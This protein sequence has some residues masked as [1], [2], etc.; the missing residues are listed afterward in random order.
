ML[1]HIQR[2]AQYS[3]FMNNKLLDAASQLHTDALSANKGAYFGSILGTLNHVLVGDLLWL[4]RF[5]H[6]STAYT[7]LNTL[8][9][10]PV[11][12]ALDQQLYN[13]LIDFKVVRQQLDT[14]ILSWVNQITA[15]DLQRALQY[16][17][18]NGE[19][20]NR[21]F[22]G[23]LMHFFNHQTHHR[24]QA[25]TLFMQA[26]IDPGDTDIVAMPGIQKA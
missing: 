2:M 24:G 22:A 3:H 13:N 7:T 21:S 26:G 17:R 20:N 9:S 16:R 6:H 18:V 10:F 5:K 14:L 15:D 4:H 1:D 19:M 25:T 12:T 8:A 23:L 11:P